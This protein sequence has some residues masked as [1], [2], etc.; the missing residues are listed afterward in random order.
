MTFSE[1]KNEIPYIIGIINIFK[2]RFRIYKEI[3]WKTKK[4]RNQLLITN[5]YYVEPHGPH[6]TFSLGQTNCYHR[7]KGRKMTKSHAK[8][9][10]LDRQITC[11]QR[12]SISRTGGPTLHTFKKKLYIYKYN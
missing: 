12:Q 3:K 11:N 2:H 8:N 4:L 7:E 5:G 10:M 6:P 1:G 9:Q